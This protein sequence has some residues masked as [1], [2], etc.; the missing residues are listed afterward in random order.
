M[1]V[2]EPLHH[3]LQSLSKDTQEKLQFKDLLRFLVLASRIKD[4][5]LLAQP[6]SWPPHVP[7]HAIP[8]AAVEFL[9]RACP[10]P[11][12]TVNTLWQHFRST[13]WNDMHTIT[14]SGSVLASFVEHGKENGFSYRTLYPPNKR[15]PNE[16]CPRTARGLSMT[17]A[18]QRQVLLLTERGTLPTWSVHLE[19][20][21]CRINYHHNFSVHQGVRTYYQGVPEVLQ[22]GEHRFAEVKLIN[23]WITLMVVAWAS[24]SN[25]ARFYNS[26]IS[27]VNGRDLTEEMEWQFRGDVTYEHV[28]D[29]FTILSLLEDSDR[30]EAILRVPHTG[31][32]SERFR[33][34]VRRLNE[35]RRFHHPQIYHAC[36]VCSRVYKG[37]F[38]RVVVVDG[39]T[40]G[41]PCCGVHNCKNPLTSNKDRFC[42]SHQ[43]HTRICCIVTCTASAVAG[44]RTCGDRAHQKVEDLYLERGTARFQ[45]QQQLQRARVAHPESSEP[46]P[47]PRPFDA[48]PLSEFVVEGAN[49]TNISVAAA[50]GGDAPLPPPASPS[51]P[52]TST[53]KRV[54]AQFGR[55]RTHNEQVLVAPCG[56]IIGRE[57]FYGAEGIGS[58]VELLKRIYRL[59]GT[60]PKH[61]FF[62]NNCSLAKMQTCDN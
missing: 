35:R 55:R 30:N 50:P 53:P 38:F 29:A 18:Q 49:V 33:E 42:S 11:L 25:C 57:T 10:L 26:A 59:E 60:E 7:P 9:S 28:Y 31:P 46:D 21:A 2:V 39:V 3:L 37:E 47:A 51:E 43:S 4:D 56:V 27:Q 23:S 5:I 24:A 40:V 6:A 22:I 36:D 44:R 41:R 19:C 34:A 17:K 54:R 8:I 16:G 13:V 48:E 62:D 12:D 1:D 32:D 61:V 45:L 15:C 20:E 58:V 52:T 14:G